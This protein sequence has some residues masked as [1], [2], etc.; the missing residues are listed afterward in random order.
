M[1]GR[2]RSGSSPRMPSARPGSEA[3]QVSC[4]MLPRRHSS[5]PH[6]KPRNMCETHA[7][8]AT[9]WIEPWHDPACRTSGNQRVGHG[10]DSVELG[11]PGSRGTGPHSVHDGSFA[12]A[13]PASSGLRRR[14]FREEQ[15][16][17]SGQLKRSGL[18]LE[19]TG[20]CHR[21]VEF[22]SVHGGQSLQGSRRWWR[23]RRDRPRRTH[24]SRERVVLGPPRDAHRS[25]PIRMSCGSRG[26]QLRV[27]L[28]HH[29]QG[30]G[31]ENVA[32]ASTS[33]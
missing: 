24:R 7:W 19:P 26:C 17:Q 16:A 29:L 9:L 20:R 5:T 4:S 18:G 10:R 30:H 28:L 11:Q 15:V 2:P 13:T 27:H 25:F 33:A 23:C 12:A 6:R 22:D 1:N 3:R 32:F 14:R 8:T 31:T 21:S